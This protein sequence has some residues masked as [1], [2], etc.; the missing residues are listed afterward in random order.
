MSATA[1]H[2]MQITKPTTKRTIRDKTN[3]QSMQNLTELVTALCPLV[4]LELFVKHRRMMVVSIIHMFWSS[5]HSLWWS[6]MLDKFGRDQ[7]HCSV[8][9]MSQTWWI[10]VAKM[11]YGVTFLQ[12]KSVI[13]KRLSFLQ[14]KSN[15]S[16]I[17]AFT[18]QNRLGNLSKNVN[19]TFLNLPRI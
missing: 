3:D 5:K 15:R 10:I 14:Q 7:P 6:L 11:S 18:S 8:A 16:D 19:L 17:F 9:K 13:S 1:C 12:Q 2:F 4:L